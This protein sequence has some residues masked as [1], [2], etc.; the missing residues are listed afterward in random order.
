MAKILCV[1]VVPHP[2]VPSNVGL[3][4]SGYGQKNHLALRLTPVIHVSKHFSTA[5]NYLKI[6]TCKAQGVPQQN[7][8]AHPKRQE[9]EETSL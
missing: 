6:T 7:N 5:F 2:V 8:A 9:E 3:F 4:P 1:K